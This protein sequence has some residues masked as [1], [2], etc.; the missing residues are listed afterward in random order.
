MNQWSCRNGARVIRVRTG[1]L[2][3]RDIRHYVKQT[4]PT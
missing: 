3:R 1:S 2:R 4:M